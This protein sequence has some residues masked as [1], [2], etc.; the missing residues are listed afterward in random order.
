MKSSKTLI[1][2]LGLLGL[3]S[4]FSYAAAVIFAPLAYPGYDWKSQ[5]VS[6]LSAIN[7][8]SRMLWDQLASLYGVC[9]IVCIMAV[10]IVIQGKLSKSLRLGIYLYAVM[11]WVSNIGYA[12]FPL[13]EGGMGFATFQDIMHAIVTVAVILLF[14]FSHIIIMIGGYHKKRF[15]SLAI[16]ATCAFVLMFV[17][18]IGTGASPPEY[19]GIFQRFS[20]MIAANGFLA[21]LGVYLFMGKFE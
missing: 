12:M 7:A 21:V 2:W 5:A 9:G 14:I 15:T 11:L 1:H 3:V 20:N 17:G 6:D 19:F 16:W 10:C 4:F 18:V 13:T 8:P